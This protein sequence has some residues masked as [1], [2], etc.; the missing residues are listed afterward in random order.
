MSLKTAYQEKL[1]A[2]LDE[3]SA[4]IELLKAQRDKAEAD[5]KIVYEQQISAV[6]GHYETAQTKMKQLQASSEAAWEELKGGIDQAW[7]SMSKA[8]KT[9]SARFTS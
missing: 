3:R 9:A 8:I 2:Q 5:A 4:K 6:Q 1:Q 7:D